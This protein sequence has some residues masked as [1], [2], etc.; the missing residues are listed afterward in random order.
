LTSSGLADAGQA[1]H[2]E[3]GEDGEGEIVRELARRAD[4]VSSGGKGLRLALNDY[5]ESAQAVFNVGIC[6]VGSKGK[7][8][9]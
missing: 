8:D 2:R 5:S 1:S 7:A 3:R 9:R 4:L 6:R